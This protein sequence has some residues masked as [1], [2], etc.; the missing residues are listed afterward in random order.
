LS[1]TSVDWEFAQRVARRVAR[2]EPFVGTDAYRGMERGF[3]ELTAQAEGLVA[4][5]TGLPLLSG[6]ARARVT[7]RS[8]WVGANVASLQR[9]RRPLTERFDAKLTGSRWAPVGRRVAGAEVGALL[10]WMSTRVLGQYDLLIVEDDR[11]EDQDIVYYVGPNLMALER[12]FAF[13][14]E[15]FRLWVALHECTHRAQFTGVPWLRPHFLSMVDQLLGS[16]DPDPARLLDALK[17][18]WQ[19]RRAGGRPLDRGGLAAVLATPEQRETLDR[20]GGLMSLLEGHGDVT[21]NLAGSG[22]VPNAWRF[23]RVLKARREQSRGLLKLLQRLVGLE[24]K[25]NQYAEGERFIAAV[26]AA[27]G[28]ALFDRVWEGPENLPNVAEIRT[29]ELWIERVQTGAPAKSA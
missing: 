5:E 25:L 11:P 13:P 4:A 22:R 1:A 28:G 20:I 26:E 14:P 12:R 29:P 16:V 24:A 23:E 19:E 8:G 18:A 10:G 27:G 17:S 3:D 9:M 2:N 7:D 6:S 15:E 21:M